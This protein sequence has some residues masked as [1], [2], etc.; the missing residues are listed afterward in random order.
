M[1]EELFDVLR[2]PVRRIGAPAVPMPFSPEL[3]RSLLPSAA[4]IV[5]AAETHGARRLTPPRDVRRREI[6]TSSAVGSRL[7]L[8]IARLPAAVGP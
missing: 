7:T 2:M 5:S 4:A 1:A 3:E 6:R 8:W